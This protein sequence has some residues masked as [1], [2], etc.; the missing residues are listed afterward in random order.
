MTAP[1]RDWTRKERERARRETQE[2]VRGL[3][4]A[5][6][7]SAKVSPTGSSGEQIYTAEVAIEK[8]RRGL[9]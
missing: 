5:A 4:D 7:M 3:T 2:H 9:A 8:R 1:G 6:L